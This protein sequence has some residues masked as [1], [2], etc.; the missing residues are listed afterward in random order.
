MKS[1]ISKILGVVLSLAL[2]SSM[3]IIAVPI[4]AAGDPDVIDVWES[5]GM[6]DTRPDSD[7][8]VS[9]VAPDGTIY[10]TVVDWIDGSDGSTPDDTMQDTEWQWS[11]QKSVD[12]GFTWNPTVIAGLDAYGGVDNVLAASDIQCSPNYNEDGRIYVGFLN[13]D[14]YRMTEEGEGT[15]ILLKEIEDEEFGYISD[16]TSGPGP[17]GSGMLYDI[18]LWSDGEAIWIMVACTL[19]VLVMEDT[20]FAEWL[21]QDLS[22]WEDDY[23]SAY[24]DPEDG[25]EVYECAFAPDFGES[26]RIWAIFSDADDES[27][28]VVS[29]I[30][31]AQWGQDMDEV[32]FQSNDTSYPDVDASPY[33]DIAFP[34]YYSEATPV[35]YV[36]LTE[37]Y[38]GGPTGDGN[39]FLVQGALRTSGTSEAEP[40]LTNDV[41]IDSVEVSGEVIIAGAWESNTIYLSQNMGNTFDVIGS[42]PI[43]GNIEGSGPTGGGYQYEFWTLN[44]YWYTF[45]QIHLAPGYDAA[46]G[47]VYVTT[48][49]IESAFSRSTD[50]GVTYQQVGLIDTDTFELRDMAFSPDSGSQPAMMLTV[51][52]SRDFS[53]TEVTA[54]LWRTLDIDAEAPQYERV[55]ANGFYSTWGS[56]SSPL[57]VFDVEYSIDEPSSA[58][59]L[60]GINMDTSSV[61]VWKSMDDGKTFSHWK[62]FP[63]WINDWVV[64]DSSTIYCATP[65]GFYGTSRFGPPTSEL[66]GEWLTSIELQPGF[67]P[68]NEDMDTII[69]GNANGQ[70]FVSLDAG[71]NWGLGNAAGT[72]F[73]YVAFD[74]DFVNN[75]LIYAAD[76][77]F[78]STLGMVSV[79]E[80]AGTVADFDALEDDTSG[81]TATAAGYFTGL[82]VSPGAEADG[83]NALYAMSGYVPGS[84]GSTATIASGG[85][86]MVSGDTSAAIDTLSLGA[87]T[88][89]MVS[90][91]FLDTEA[92]NILGYALT[93]S[94]ITDEISG[95]IVVSGALSGA[96]GQITVSMTVADAWGTEGETVS[97]TGA[98]ITAT[99]TGGT[100]GVDPVDAQLW[101]LLLHEEDSV[102]ETASDVA[103][104]LPITPT[105]S[106]S[107][108]VTPG[109]NLVWTMDFITATPWVLE[110]TVCIPVTGVTAE[111]VGYETATLSW[112]AMTGADEYEYRW[113]G[114]ADTTD[115]DDTEATLAGL[116][117]NE[118]YTFMVRVE[119]GM[120]F[121]SRWSTGYDFTTLEL[122]GMPDNEVPYNGEQN[123]STRPSFVWY[124]TTGT[125]VSYEFQLSTDP[126]FGTTIVNITINAPLTAYTC[127][128]DLAYDTDH[129]WQV[130]A[131]SATGTKS[132]WCFSNFHTML[133]PKDPITIEPAPT[134]TIILP[135]PV[136]NVPEITMPDIT[137][138]P[139]AVTVNLP[140]PIQTEVNPVIQMPDNPTP[141]YIWL[142]VAIGAVLTIAVIVLI[143]RTRR[144]V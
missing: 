121:T 72:F 91:V 13:G 68:D 30:L 63:G 86:V 47:T 80:L 48:A 113:D 42:D 106:N 64:L 75:G 49:G 92:L 59:M 85:T 67:N 9:T 128:V 111:S 33:V 52:T 21:D 16:F 23:T 11:V 99:V 58:I 46:D 27:F 70:V 61:V 50:G 95:V 5:V 134:P 1:K 100:S 17:G 93:Y 82:A 90:G 56:W 104:T 74:A 25:S 83:G 125:P 14:V 135:T 18:D 127:T 43:T 6:P 7:I 107:L 102:W 41:G 22:T 78:G 10:A 140:T 20:N 89:S 108:W 35:F 137:V 98:A 142:I 65:D 139:P 133:E 34:E 81:A 37:F 12:E 105:F 40:L 87:P 39:L 76:S 117:D 141:V 53:T 129:Y 97:V 126:A 138:N 36:G 124:P 132:P 112:D 45:T 101:R 114:A 71:D 123:I 119:E 73:T 110:D 94:D 69:V 116:D 31:P 109:S 28:W 24:Y 136:V 54:S 19:D 88:I 66:A 2:L 51:G 84:S 143:I 44:S 118:D 29:T 79:A 130:R 8:G 103:L 15:A 38:S 26:S 96:V 122:I 62:T 115:G 57:M 144:V 55:A 60:F 77:G 131:V 120:P 3:A 4:S 32:C